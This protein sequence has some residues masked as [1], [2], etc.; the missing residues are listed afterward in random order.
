[1]GLCGLLGI[2]RLPRLLATTEMVVASVRPSVPQR[3]FGSRIR[4]SCRV[5]L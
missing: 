3:V 2:C 1:M 5:L 4:L